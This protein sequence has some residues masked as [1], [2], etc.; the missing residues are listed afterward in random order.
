MDVEFDVKRCYE[1]VMKLV[2]QAG[3]VSGFSL[4]S[5]CVWINES[6]FEK[7]KLN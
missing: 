7:N 1:V 3:D 6:P 2:D 4:G 5:N